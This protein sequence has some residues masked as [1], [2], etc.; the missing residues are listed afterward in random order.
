MGLV[1]HVEWLTESEHRSW[2]ALQQMQSRVTAELA[3]RLVAETGL[4]YQDYTVLVVLTANE[5]G[6]LR[7]FAL[8]REMGWE[9]SRMSHHIGRMVKR[10]LVSKERCP[11]DGRG[12]SVVVTEQ[13]RHELE[14][15]APGH[16]AAVRELFIDRLS[17][18]QLEALGEAAETILAGMERD[19][20]GHDLD[21]E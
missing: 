18:S 4:S 16:V 20:L 11:S 14:A 9:K 15:A 8:G 5:D 13:G 17:E 7:L 19:G 3:R 6:A 21:C 12:W 1:E 10:G 2:R